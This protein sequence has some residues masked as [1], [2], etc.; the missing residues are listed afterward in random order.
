MHADRNKLF[1]D[2]V[3]IVGGI[4]L[5]KLK[6]IN[7]LEIIQPEHLIKGGF[8]RETLWKITKLHSLSSGFTLVFAPGGTFSSNSVKYVSMSQN[9]LV[10]QKEERARYG[11][12]FMKLRLDLLEKIQT[13]SF[14]NAAGIIYISDFAR[15]YISK[16][17]GVINASSVKISHGISMRFNGSIKVQRDI[18]SYTEQSPYRI[19]YVS[20]IDVYKHQDRVIEA[21]KKLKDAGYNVHLDLVGGAYPPELKKISP[22]LNSNSHI[23]TYHGLQPYDMIEKFYHHADAFVF[24]S[25]CENMPNILIEAMKSGLPLASSELAPMKEFLQDAGFYFDPLD[26][27]S[28]FYSIEQLL[29]NKELRMEKAFKGI[30]LA[31]NYNWKKCADETITFLNKIASQSA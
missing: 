27:D 25:S 18:G 9:M 4:Q 15:N 10:F 28:I 6:H 14:R 20:I 23:V 17:I 16:S 3:A 19:L 13:K 21:V 8:L 2:K 12:S 5:D 29:L 30:N 7:W 22:L 24:A 31:G 26:T 11:F 1:F